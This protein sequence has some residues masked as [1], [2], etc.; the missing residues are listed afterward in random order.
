MI[1]FIDGRLD[2]RPL[3]KEDKP[4]LPIPYDT[5]VYSEDVQDG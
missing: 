3:A 4:H 5:V 2:V 1:F